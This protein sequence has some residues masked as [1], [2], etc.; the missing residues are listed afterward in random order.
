MN[1]PITIMDALEATA[2]AL[3][4]HNETFIKVFAAL[5]MQ[6]KSILCL[7]NIVNELNQRLILL[8]GNNEQAVLH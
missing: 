1:T 3:E 7:L 6:Q 4:S 5:E 8:E 2:K